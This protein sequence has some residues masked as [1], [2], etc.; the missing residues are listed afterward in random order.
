MSQSLPVHQGNPQRSEKWTNQPIVEVERGV[1]NDENNITIR[2]AQQVS[3]LRPQYIFNPHRPADKN[4][5]GWSCRVC[6]HAECPQYFG[7]SLNRSISQ[8]YQTGCN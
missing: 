2:I 4:G 6:E 3:H 1:N 8:I 7:K 5:V